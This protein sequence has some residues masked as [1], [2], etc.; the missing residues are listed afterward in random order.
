[1]L[2]AKPLRNRRGRSIGHL[3]PWRPSR[4]HCFSSAREIQSTP[5]FCFSRAI[6]STQWKLIA[7]QSYSQISLKKNSSFLTKLLKK[8]KIESVAYSS[9]G[10]HTGQLDF[11]NWLTDEWLFIIIIK[12][13]VVLLSFLLTSWHA[14]VF[15]PTYFGGKGLHLR[16]WLVAQPF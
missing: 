10:S 8:I 2:L 5:T 13:K 1:M 9:Q 14:C 16:R 6:V 11:C 4:G 7:T 12:S 3:S 15:L